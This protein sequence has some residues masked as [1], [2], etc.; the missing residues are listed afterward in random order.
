MGEKLKAPPLVEALCEFRFGAGTPW[1]WTVPGRLYER[2]KDDFPERSEVGS[3]SFG[4][5]VAAPGQPIPV[6][7]PAGVPERVQ[8]K[9]K[10]GSALV[11][12]APYRLV[13]NHLRPYKSWESFRELIFGIFDQYREIVYTVEVDQVGLR[14]IN[15]IP[16][17]PP[18]EE[19]IDTVTVR[20]N[21]TS[22][23][24]QPLK[25]FFQRYEL[26]YNSPRGVLIH[27]TGT[28]EINGRTVIILDLDFV[29]QDT[30]R[31]SN[32]EEIEKFLDAAHDRIGEAFV[33]SID[34][35]LYERLR[36]GDI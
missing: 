8:L 20:P 11:Q 15:Q 13:I 31:L 34:P 30:R 33:A 14:Y 4:L 6:S 17:V 27:Q 9:R 3:H 1:D 32:M 36:S 5:V 16:M 2:I 10:D 28:T 24:A 22:P 29:S 25:S 7:P 12:V 26:E 18:Y 19:Y 23:L 35:P 21:F